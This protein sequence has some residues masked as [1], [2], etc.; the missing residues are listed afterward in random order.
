MTHGGGGGQTP[1]D[2]QQYLS[3]D[4]GQLSPQDQPVLLQNV[5]TALT[6]RVWRSAYA[7]RW[8]SLITPPR[9][10]RRTIDLHDLRSVR[11]RLISGRAGY[12]TYV[13]VTDGAG[14]R[15]SFSGEQDI[16]RIR[17]AVKHWM[18]KDAPTV[19]VSGLAASVLGLKPLRFSQ[20]ALYS[21]WSFVPLML[22]ILAIE[23]VI[24]ALA[25]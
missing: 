6:R 5:A 1:S 10:F 13:V 7:A 2:Q 8:Y 11:A 23:G 25:A 14:V 18:R 20:E 4:Y 15:M 16:E 24:T 17:H 21:L 22:A 9:I 12:T 3:Q 19:R